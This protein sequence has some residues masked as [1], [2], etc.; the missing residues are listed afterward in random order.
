MTARGVERRLAAL[1]QTAT[2]SND[3]QAASL[4]IIYDAATGK[5][6]TPVRG[7]APVTVWLPDNH[8]GDGGQ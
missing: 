7:H 2:D 8:R 3:G 4:V 6:L 1:E 5:P